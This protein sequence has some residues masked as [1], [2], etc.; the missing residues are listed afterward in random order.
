M[1]S[2]AGLGAYSSLLDAV[3]GLRWPAR[4]P[5]PGGTHG[6]HRSRRRG[7]TAEF[8]EYQAYRP[9]DDPRRLDWKLLARSD[10]AFVRLTDDHAVFPTLLVVDASASMAFPERTLDKWR[11]A[12][13]VAVGLAAVAH[14]AGDPVG[15]VVVGGGA[16]RR[17]EPRT[18]R[19]VVGE[20]ARA[21][22]E[23]VPSGDGTIGGLLTAAGVA[24]GRVVVISDFLAA[25]DDDESA[26]VTAVRAWPECYAVHVVAAEELTPDG[27]DAVVRDPERTD[28]ARPLVGGSDGRA[29]YSATFSAWRDELARRLQSRGATYTMSVTSGRGED[30]AR[31]AERA[32]RQVVLATW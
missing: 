22:D 9:G 4:R 19:G 12:S 26:L 23:T 16:V 31:Q 11:H 18:R 2:V 32:V 17:L 20:I 5:V 10:R 13:A 14:A 8:S 7:T 6:I 1:S 29:A 27:G 24:R 25:S 3:R 15:C 30:V 28:V 21:L